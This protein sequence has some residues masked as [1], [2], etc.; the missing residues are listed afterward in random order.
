MT[1]DTW[2]WLYSWKLIALFVK[3][4]VLRIHAYLNKYGN[5]S[6]WSISQVLLIINQQFLCTYVTEARWNCRLLSK[7]RILYA[8]FEKIKI[9]NSEIRREMF[10]KIKPRFLQAKKYF[11]VHIYDHWLTL[12][13]YIFT[14]H[15]CKTNFWWMFLLKNS[16]SLHVFKCS[17]N[18]L[19]N[20][21]SWF[22][23]WHTTRLFWI[24]KIFPNHLDFRCILYILFLQYVLSTKSICTGRLTY[25]ILY[26]T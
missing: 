18:F 7:F 4:K 8:V 25:S 13:S 14:S 2:S 1:W 23:K 6:T 11:Y 10:L 12:G 3:L 19:T 20:N 21:S 24:V 15:F 16:M 9:S 22:S 17:T 26:C 5:K